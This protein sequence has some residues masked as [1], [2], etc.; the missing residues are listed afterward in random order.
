MNSI[1]NIL[2]EFQNR[3]FGSEE[4]P[5]SY[6]AASIYKYTWE[7]ITDFEPKTN[8]ESEYKERCLSTMKQIGTMLGISENGVITFPH[9]EECCER[10][11]EIESFG[12]DIDACIVDLQKILA[13]IDGIENKE[14]EAAFGIVPHYMVIKLNCMREHLKC[15]IKEFSEER[16][17]S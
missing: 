17:N 8:E 15:L 2:I 13:E 4:K 6:E 16:N 7:S 1:Q 9:I 14:L 12:E 10:I 3:I 11:Y 5:S